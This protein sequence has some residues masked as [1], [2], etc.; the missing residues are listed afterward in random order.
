MSDPQRGGGHLAQMSHAQERM[1]FAHAAAPGSSTYNEALLFTWNEPVDTGSLATALA[2]L[3]RRHEILRTT[4]RMDGTRLLQEVAG[5]DSA[6]P[7]IDAVDLGGSPEAGAR[8]M[9]EAHRCAR[10]PFDLEKGPVVRCHVW[11]GAP[12]GDAV[13]FAFHHIAVDGGSYPLLFE[14]LS[15]IYDAV[16]TGEP[17]REQG[18]VLRYTDH[19]VRERERTSQPQHTARVLE[20][21]EQLAGFPEGPVLAGHSGRAAAPDGSRPGSQ[22]PVALEAGLREQL[23]RAAKELRVTPYVVV[24]AAFQAT[25]RLWSGQDRFLLG[26][27]LD[28]RPSGEAQRSVGLFVNTVPLRCEVDTDLS[29][30]EL[31]LRFRAEAYRS[32]SHRALPYEQLNS[33]VSARR[34]RGHTALVNTGLVYQDSLWAAQ[35]SRRRWGVPT[36]LDTGTA[37]FDLLLHVDD[38]PEAVSATLEHDTDLYSE[39]AARTLGAAF[40]DVLAAVAADPERRIGELPGAPPESLSR[41]P[42]GRTPA[43]PASALGEDIAAEDRARAVELFTDAL[44]EAS[45]VSRTAAADLGPTS[46]FFAL[47]GHSLAAVAMLSRARRRYGSVVA[48]RDFL[49]NPTVAHLA[50]LLAGA[51]VAEGPVPGGV[52]ASEDTED[53]PATSTQQ[54]FWFLDRVPEQRSAY[55][56]PTVVEYTGE[57]D[58]RAL[59]RAVTAVLGHHP[60]LRA[61]FRLDRTLRTLVYRT[62][63]TSAEATF[64][65]ARRW[66]LERLSE[67]VAELSRAGFD[68]AREAPARAEV[69]A[70]ETG[71]LLVL[72]THH[73]VADGWSRDLILDHITRLYRA[74]RTGG[75]AELPAPVHPARLAPEGPEGVQERTSAVVDRLRDAPTDISLPHDRPRGESQQVRALRA[76]TALGP[77]LTRRVRS[78]AVSEAGCTTFMAAAALVGTALAGHT[79]QHDLLLAFPWAGREAP[80]SADAVAM[81]VNTLVL[82]IDLTGSPTWRELLE[83]VKENSR[84]CYRNSDVPFDSLVAHLHPGRDLSRP[85]LTPVYLAFWDGPPRVPVLDSGV[86]ALLLPPDPPHIKYEIEFDVVEHDEDIVFTASALSALFDPTTVQSL[87]D[88]VVTAAE[89]LAAAPDSYAIQGGPA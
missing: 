74:E 28:D 81:L 47:G 61:R 4:Y 73:I 89:G 50:R 32:L 56:M 16:R 23:H 70:T 71:A 79:G 1:W 38:S 66:P 84:F 3:V 20:R 68:L 9:S 57:V 49:A 14:E 19:A 52:P 87:L 65:D 29:F 22:Q 83:Q 21:A 51:R 54:R 6:L 64:T 63:G 37:K 45:A 13:L 76:E 24:A 10:R 7:E 60:A 15:E 42:A 69:I 67:H 43:V 12:G 25:L 31:C 55:L 40:A 53:H 88:A 33:A 77:E 11:S 41:P 2:I 46:D 85:P 86:E 17:L 59:R 44:N 78:V 62:D 36:L 30:S 80:G 75:R 34:G 26:A 48:P 82:R 18:P 72:V 39:D 5:A 58:H 8:L 27:I 35:D